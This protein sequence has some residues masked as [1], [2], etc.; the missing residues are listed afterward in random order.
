[1]RFRGINDTGKRS[2]KFTYWDTLFDIGLKAE[3]GEFG[4]Y[5]KTW[6]WET[7]FR[8]SRNEGQ[9][10]SVG[11]VS[12]PGLRQALLDTDPATAFNP[13]LGILG[14]NS[15]AARSTVYVT[16]QNT[17][18]F[19][20]P[21]GYA[22]INGDLFNLPAGPVSFAI[23]DEYRGE[24]MTRDRDPLNQTFNSIGQVDGQGF[25]ANRDVWSIYEEVRVPFTSATWNFPC[26]YSFE[27]DFA[28]R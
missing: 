24:R 20:L 3:M 6:N 9:D 15:R 7:G 21:L 4:D 8:Y 19:E 28:E 2:E 10:L 16:L 11:E 17:G 14:R 22:T 23:G 27:V 5:F 25:R 13:F 26:F 18:E 1:M 12:Q